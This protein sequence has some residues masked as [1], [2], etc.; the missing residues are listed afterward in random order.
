M[1]CV[2]IVVFLTFAL[3]LWL[4]PGEATAG[5]GA[6]VAEFNILCQAVI[7]EDAD[8]TVD[9]CAAAVTDAEINDIIQLNVSAA[10]DSWYS[11]FPKEYPVEEPTAKAAGC[12]GSTDEKRC[13]ANWTKWT[14]ARANL[15]K[16]VTTEP[17]LN[18]SKLSK[19]QKGASR[20]IAAMQLLAAEA[21]SELSEYNSNVRPKLVKENNAITAAIKADLCGKGAAKNDCT[22]PK[23]MGALSTRNNDCKTPSAGKSIVGDLFCLCAVDST[24]SAAKPCGFDTPTAKSGRKLADTRGNIQSSN[25]ARNKKGMQGK[26][27]TE[28]FGRH[29]ALNTNQVSKQAKR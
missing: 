20:Y 16:R 23:T 13:I 25:V 2:A 8:P 24:H 3:N 19:K 1:N 7:L 17:H 6:N 26:A 11:K 18:P 14:K 9:I 5:D 4:R 15:L 27:K 29:P 28:A 12:S 21:E 10:A 22:D